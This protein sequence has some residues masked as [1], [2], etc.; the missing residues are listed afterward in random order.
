MEEAAD[1]DGEDRGST[2]EVE[3]GIWRAFVSIG[4]DDPGGDIGDICGDM[5]GVVVMMNVVMCLV[6]W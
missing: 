1:G 3:S 4:L 6:S 5:F 2:W